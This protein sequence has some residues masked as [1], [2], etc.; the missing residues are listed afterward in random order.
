MNER[1]SRA[2][3]S[4]WRTRALSLSFILNGGF[5]K[6]LTAEIP[7]EFASR[8]QID[9]TAE[10]P[11]ELHFHSNKTEIT[12][13]APWFELYQHVNIAFEERS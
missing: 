13:N 11:G 6:D 8:A 3:S 2:A 1:A 12:G 10:H 7:A 4:M 5:R 9:F